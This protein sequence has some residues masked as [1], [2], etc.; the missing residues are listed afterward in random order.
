MKILYVYGSSTATNIVEVLKKLKYD[1][2]EYP[3]V[4]DTSEMEETKINQVVDYI[5]EYEITHLMSIH[6]IYSI[7]VA[8]YWAGIKYVPVIW[9]APYL[10]SYTVMGRLDNIWYSVFDKLDAERMRQDGCP[11]VLYQP[12]SVNE[13]RL[14]VWEKESLLKV[15]YS[16]DISFIGNLYERN[17]YDQ[18]LGFIPENMQAYFRSI[19]EE[20]AFKWDGV[21]RV[22]GQTTK[23]I[24]DY[25]SLM[26]PEFK[27]G[28]PF[29][30]EDVR[31]FEVAY[32]IR[33]LANIERIC[34]L[35]MLAERHEVYLYTNSRVDKALLPWVHIEPP[36]VTGEATSIIFAG[37]KINLNISLKGIEGGTPQR[38]MDIMGA[39][40]FVLT[41]YCEETAEIFKEDTEIVMFRTPEELLEKVDYYL[42]HD[43]EREQIA[44]A[45]HD[46]VLNC[47]TYGKKMK[48][49]LDWVESG[50]QEFKADKDRSAG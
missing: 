19:F 25:I 22:Y 36:V 17:D 8:A 12:L 43:A 10:K 41:N 7:A 24:L 30:V 26:N 37:S 29:D 1:V 46:K 50:E 15:K 45:G 49:L 21:N 5:K 42:T 38:I 20:A 4:Q 47:Y 32:L 35:N 44:R 48:Q 9:D 31:Y 3:E 40:G 13:D 14:A 16:N 11:H 34:V 28:N 33:K 2:V 27:L 23:E 6:L 39:G 18:C